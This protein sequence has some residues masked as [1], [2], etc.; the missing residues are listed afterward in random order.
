MISRPRDTDS[1]NPKPNSRPIN[2]RQS[3]AK[4]KIYLRAEAGMVNPLVIK[5]ALL[6]EPSLSFFVKR[7][8]IFS[9]PPIILRRFF[10]SLSSPSTRAVSVAVAAFLIPLLETLLGIGVDVLLRLFDADVA[11]GAVDPVV[12]AAGSVDTSA[13]ACFLRFFEPGA[14]LREW[15]RPCSASFWPRAIR[16]CLS[17]SLVGRI[18]MMLSSVYDSLH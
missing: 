14:F 13:A 9:L 5:S 2:A 11:L 7:L 1:N 3:E 17:A 18:G 6:A 4:Q 15:A 10:L 16:R 12:S 8:S